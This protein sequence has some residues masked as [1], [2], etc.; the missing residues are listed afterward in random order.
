MDD[1]YTRSYSEESFWDKLLRYAKAA[2][3]EV[4]ERALQLYYAAQ[5]PATPAWARTVIYGALG[6]FIFPVDAIPDSIPAVGYVDDLG[7]LAA[8]IAAVAMYITPEVKQKAKQKLQD[9]FG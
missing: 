2:G 6:Y 3:A 4:I 9:W 5:D 8:A 1:E 7:V